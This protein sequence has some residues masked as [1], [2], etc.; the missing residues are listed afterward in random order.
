VAKTTNF[1][2]EV[3]R[4][5]LSVS[6]PSSIPA[7][8][9]VRAFAG[10][11]SEHAEATDRLDIVWP[12]CWFAVNWKLSKSPRSMCNEQNDNDDKHRCDGAH[13]KSVAVMIV[14]VFKRKA[15]VWTDHRSNCRPTW[16]AGWR[17]SPQSSGAIDFSSKLS[18]DYK[19]GIRRHQTLPVIRSFI[20]PSVSFY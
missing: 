12:R 13:M 9:A 20:W 3:F 18:A 10:N 1:R 2:L 15:A 5:T 16:S 11:I 19:Q 17:L 7:D 8:K 14:H 4:Q 6:F